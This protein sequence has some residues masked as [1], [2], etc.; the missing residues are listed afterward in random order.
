MGEINMII[1]CSRRTDIP[2][3]YSDWFFNRLHAGYVQVRNP[4]NPRQVRN[5]SLAPGDVDGIVFW[6]K[7]PAP[8]LNRLHLLKDYSYYFQFTLTP[9]D[10]EIEPNLPPKTEIVDTFIRLAD[11]IGKKRII[12][13]Y[14]P[15]LLSASIDV[16]YHID[17]F[18]ELATR[19]S[20]YTQKCVISFIDMYH[21]LQSGTARLFVRPPDETEM[22]T[23]AE[24]FAEIAGANNI[25]VAT[26]AEKIDLADLGIEHGKCIDDRLI[27]ELT[28]TRLNIAKDKSQRELCGC[29]TSV[30]IGEYNTC[31]HRCRY[32]YANASQKKIEKNL[33]LH[34]SHS[35][36]LIGDN[37][38]CK[39][40]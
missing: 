4:M 34:Y 33:S 9:Y 23:L 24:N 7:D 38:P 3:F 6:T 12:W 31:R 22:R 26:C 30:D 16:A 2:A 37:S 25:A 1:S 17:H 5:V 32:C 27:A 13:R 11:Q 36:L 29:V 35:P 15:I 40:Q 20:S 10:R 28:G 8:M 14:D 21:H 19:L 39:S 18:S